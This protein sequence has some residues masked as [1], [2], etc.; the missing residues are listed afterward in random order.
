MFEAHVSPIS[1]PFL[2]DCDE[3]FDAVDRNVLESST[4]NRNEMD[5]LVDSAF[6]LEYMNSLASF[7]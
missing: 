7:L 5:L 4:E 3:F 1:L 2:G 6:K